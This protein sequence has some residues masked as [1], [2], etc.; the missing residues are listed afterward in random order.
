MLGKGTLKIEDHPDCFVV[1]YVHRVGLWHLHSHPMKG[2]NVNDSRQKAK[3]TRSLALLRYLLALLEEYSKEHKQKVLDELQ[4]YC[5]AHN[6]DELTFVTGNIVA[7]FAHRGY[8][9]D[10]AEVIPQTIHDLE[11]EWI[12]L[13]F[14]PSRQPHPVR[15]ETRRA[16]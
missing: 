13:G 9:K 4:A 10:V 6:R 8:Q 15:K 16:S 2:G 12:A 3:L 1:G 11:C 14:D 5:R 7:S